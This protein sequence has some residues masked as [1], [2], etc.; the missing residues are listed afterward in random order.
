MNPRTHVTITVD[1][2]ACLGI[3]S[4]VAER[5]GVSVQVAV[6]AR[7]EAMLPNSTSPRG[8]RSRSDARVRAT[9]EAEEVLPVHG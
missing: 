9:P 1:D 6:V 8:S 2:D 3:L 5:C 4:R 7:L